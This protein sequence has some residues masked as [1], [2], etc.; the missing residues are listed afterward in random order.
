LEVHVSVSEVAVL[1]APFAGFG[2]FGVAGGAATVLNDHTGP[3]VEPT[4]FLA[5][6]LQK[7]V[8]EL[9]SDDTA[10]DAAVRPVVTCGGGFD[11]PK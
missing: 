2:E 10:Y 5:T 9:A 7:Y 11:V 3:V 4:A 1:V 8:V 6:I